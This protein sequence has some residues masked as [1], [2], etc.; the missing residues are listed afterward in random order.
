MIVTNFFEALK[1]GKEIANANAW[2][3]AQ[4]LLNKRGGVVTFALGLARLF[5]VNLAMLEVAESAG[6][7]VWLEVVN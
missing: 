7:P 5:G 1:P 2:K 3:E 4:P 6:R